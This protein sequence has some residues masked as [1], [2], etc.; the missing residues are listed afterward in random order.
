M[1]QKNKVRVIVCATINLANVV[2]DIL[3]KL[4][5]PSTDANVGALRLLLQMARDKALAGW[6]LDE[7]NAYRQIGFLPDHKKYSVV[8]FKH[9]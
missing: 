2:S 1:V 9:F 6:V 8:A 3:E 7:R 5:L 4:Q